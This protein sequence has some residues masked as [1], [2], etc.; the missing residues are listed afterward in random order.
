MSNVFRK[1]IQ[2]EFGVENYFKYYFQY[3]DIIYGEKR[4][5]I[6]QPGKKEV[7]DQ[8]YEIV[9]RKD[10]ASLNI[11]KERV[12][13]TAA[14]AFGISKYFVFVVLA[15]LL[16]TLILLAVEIPTYILITGMTGVTVCFAGKTIEYMSNRYCF[17]DAYLFNVYR[18]V[19]A[20]V[21]TERE[22]F[23]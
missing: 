16:S 18:D 19:L 11:M 5:E 22:K 23:I 3:Q 21:I 12:E 8:M 6:T 10:K 1:L 15:Y 17:I 9:V 14:M 7:Y 4:E 20:K 13:N 2:K